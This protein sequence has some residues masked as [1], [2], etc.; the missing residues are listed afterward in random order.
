MTEGVRIPIDVSTT[1]KESVKKIK[2]E[3]AKVKEEVEELIQKSPEVEEKSSTGTTSTKK[4]K[5]SKKTTDK[6]EKKIDKVLE[7]DLG[8]SKAGNLLGYATNPTGA[9]LQQLLKIGVLPAAIIGAPVIAAKVIE[10]LQTE[11][12]LLD[13]F[14]DDR[15]DNRT[16]ALRDKDKL[17]RILQGFDSLR[18]STID[19]N[20]DPR[21][22]YNSFEV[23]KNNRT[24]L[25]NDFQIRKT[26]T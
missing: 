6:K 23:F 10:F 9:V 1:G 22:I 4:G 24:L 25:E 18:I 3:V 20:S 14:F 16:D 5:G 13:R 2:E 15:I 21:N 26:I 12:N 8:A 11:G 7:Q 17:Q 19:G